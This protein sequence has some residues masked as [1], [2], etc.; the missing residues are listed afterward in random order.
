MG[1][2]IRAG[3]AADDQI[4]DAR[5]TL[6]NA[7]AAGGK[8]KQRAEDGLGP[9]V[10]MVDATEAEL[11]AA[12]ALYSPLKAAVV[13]ENDR[14]DAILDRTYDDTWNDVGRPA[15]DRHLALMFPGGAAYYTDGDT[16]NQPAR[17]ELLAKLY[18]RK[19]HPKL[20]EAQC[21]TYAA[22]IRDAASALKADID[23]AAGPAENVALLQR[24]WTSLGRICQFELAS[25]KRTFKNDGMTEAQIHAVIPDRP[26]AKK[27]AKKPDTSAPD[28]KKPPAD[29]T[30]PK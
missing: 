23:A 16:P 19:L 3:A 8:I 11:N 5:T 9:V 1:E 30:E 26:V 24:V 18:D 22:R 10:A 27:A 12:I 25:L 4:K 28:A 6:T 7:I 21:Q 14:A 15:S 2:V 20:S 17:M 29:S 13:A